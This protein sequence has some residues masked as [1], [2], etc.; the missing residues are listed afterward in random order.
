M[1]VYNEVWRRTRVAAFTPEMA[2]GPLARTPYDLRHA[3]ISTL[4]AM[5]ISPAQVAEWAGNSVEVIY[6][7]Y[8][9]VIHGGEAPVLDE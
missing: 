5:G 8:A 9:K 2:A 4:P 6:K 1:R 3:W 7:V